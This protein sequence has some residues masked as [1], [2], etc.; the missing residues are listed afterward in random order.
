MCVDYLRDIVT[1]TEAWFPW[2]PARSLEEE[3]EF[4]GHTLSLLPPDQPL[5]NV[6]IVVYLVCVCVR[7][8]VC[9]CVSLCVLCIYSIP[10]P[11]RGPM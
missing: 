3:L 7:V 8:C 4:E 10:V 11:R 5:G 1:E 2:R 6:D 9:V